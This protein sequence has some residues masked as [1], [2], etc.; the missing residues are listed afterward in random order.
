M[1]SACA[2]RVDDRRLWHGA[3]QGRLASVDSY[4]GSLCANTVVGYWPGRGTSGLGR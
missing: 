1:L 2:V 4:A 3:E